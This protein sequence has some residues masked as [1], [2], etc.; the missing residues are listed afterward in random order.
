MEEKFLT[1]KMLLN[2]AN[3][4]SSMSISPGGR[5]FLFRVMYKIINFEGKKTILDVSDETRNRNFLKKYPALFYRLSEYM[6]ILG[7]GRR[8]LVVE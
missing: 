3:A 6:N 1:I 2:A 8:P 4:Y 7:E 5:D